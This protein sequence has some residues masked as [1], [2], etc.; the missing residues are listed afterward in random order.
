MLDVTYGYEAKS[1]QDD[2]ICLAEEVLS[3][4]SKAVQPGAHLVD[5]FPS[6]K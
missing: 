6:R 1:A 5:I 2:L 3:D 4:V